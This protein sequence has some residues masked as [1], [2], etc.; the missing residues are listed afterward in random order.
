[1]TGDLVQDLHHTYDAAGNVTHVHDDAQD[2]IWFANQQVE[3]SR[4]HTY[5]A[6]D[7]LTESEGRENATAVGPPAQPPGSWPVGTF[8]SGDATRRYT[9][10][11]RYDRAGNIEQVRH[12]AGT[13]NSWTR[14]HTYAADSNRLV[15]TWYG[16]A[17]W[18][19]TPGAQRT[20]HRHDVHGNLLNLAATAPGRDLRWDHRDVI[21][22]ADLLGGGWAHY[23]H[24]SDKQRTRK[25][26]ESDGTTEERIYLGGYERYRRWVGTTLVEEI[27]SSH[28][29]AGEQRVLLVD[30]VRSS[31]S[32]AIDDRT[33]LRYQYGDHQGSVGTELD[34]SAR[35]ISYEELHP[36]GTSAYRRA[37]TAV[38]APPRR[39]RYTG[40]ETDDETGLTRHGARAC[41]PWLGRWISCD[42]IGLAGGSNLYAYAGGN[43]VRYVDPSGHKPKTVEDDPPAAKSP[44]AKAKSPEANDAP[45]PGA[46]PAHPSPYLT[47]S[48]VPTDLKKAR[49]EILDAV[50]R[51]ADPT[52]EWQRLFPEDPDDP[53]HNFW[54]AYAVNYALIS[55]GFKP[56]GKYGPKDA[57][58]LEEALWFLTKNLRQA[59]PKIGSSESLILR[60]AQRYLY[61]AQGDA[62]L[63]KYATDKYVKSFLPKEAAPVV[64]AA[65]PYLSGKLIDRVYEQGAKRAVMTGNAVVEELTGH[66]PGWLRSSHDKPHSRTGGEDWYDLG[67]ASY[68]KSGKGN[69]FIATTPPSVGGTA[70][71][72]VRLEDFRTIVVPGGS[73][74]TKT[75]RFQPTPNTLPR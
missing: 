49:K 50:G 38:E 23:Q 59:D 29:F 62:W 12:E 26:I 48:T 6:L 47:R 9:E 69:P 3:P 70:P 15:R 17:D 54:V 67:M 18:D 14:N 66:N 39:Y 25:R 36:Y 57:K 28:R 4:D 10:R 68:G 51:E 72:P 60:D 32:A 42:P 8:P 16:T 35:V 58:K 31:D 34:A 13:N 19:H 75:F 27:E 63:S 21:G 11:Y 61:G 24:G 2:T 53:E 56:G 71:N 20:E 43:P 7:R 74:D 52:R 30:D 22:S 45:E 40:M 65:R 41:A 1:V 44:A 33:L 46:G 73:F 37:S 5:D 55:K 64:D